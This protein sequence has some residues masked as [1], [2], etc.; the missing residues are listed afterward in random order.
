MICMM[1]DGD[2]MTAMVTTREAGL[3]AV[4]ARKKPIDRERPNQVN[5]TRRTVILLTNAIPDKKTNR[6]PGDF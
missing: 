5:Y 2:R 3:P 6:V 4:S 1:K